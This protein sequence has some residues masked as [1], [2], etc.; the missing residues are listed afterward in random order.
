MVINISLN[1]S[2]A[3]PSV[4]CCPKGGD[5]EA[6]GSRLV[7]TSSHIGLKSNVKFTVHCS[8]YFI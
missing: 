8:L 7:P 6:I 2:K 3:L 5:G 1:Y 4:L